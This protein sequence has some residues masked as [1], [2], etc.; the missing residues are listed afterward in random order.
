MKKSTISAIA[1]VSVAGALVI[2]LGAVSSWF[3][4]WNVKTWFGRGGD[5]STEQPETPKTDE[6]VKV[7]DQSGIKLMAKAV[8]VEDYEA[9]GIASEAEYSYTLTATV[10]PEFADN[11][12]LDWSVSWVNENSE[13]ASGKTVTD[14]VKVVELSDGTSARID[15]YQ[16]FGSQISV[17]CVSQDNP[18]AYGVCLVDFQKKL[19]G[20]TVGFYSQG[21]VT[22]YEWTLTTDTDTVTPVPSGAG[23]TYIRK[24]LPTYSVYTV[25]NYSNVDNVKVELRQNLA[26]FAKLREYSEFSNITVRSFDFYYNFGENLENFLLG[27]N[28][29][30]FTFPHMKGQNLYGID[31]SLVAKACEIAKTCCDLPFFYLDFIW[32][33]GTAGANIGKTI[34]L[35]VYCSADG[36]KISVSSVELGQS[37]IIL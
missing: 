25:D 24:I 6:L 2:G 7:V 19:V 17:R 4:N 15:C 32:Q 9:N 22:Y 10:S 18:N 36:F 5:S 27:V 26:F 28:R 23:Y 13:F 11:K 3:T 34:T 20:V 31:S 21:E 16:P 35:P 12:A 8:A 33:N 1:A 29:S 30:I 14:Y 37:G